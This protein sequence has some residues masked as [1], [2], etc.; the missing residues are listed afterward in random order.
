MLKLSQWELKNLRT[1]NDLYF[2]ELIENN[3]DFIRLVVDEVDI[4]SNVT[5]YSYEGVMSP[6]A[7]QFIQDNW[8]KITKYIKDNG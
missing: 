4:E 1:R 7:E 5:S 2:L 8:Q 6:I 3:G